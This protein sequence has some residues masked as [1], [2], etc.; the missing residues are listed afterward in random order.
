MNRLEPFVRNF[1][2]EAD[3]RGLPRSPLDLDIET[4]VTAFLVAALC[5]VAII[6]CG[7]AY[8]FL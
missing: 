7:A 8:V 3:E 1:D 2:A 6:L 5:V 4:A